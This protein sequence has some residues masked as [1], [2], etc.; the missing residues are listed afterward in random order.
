MPLKNLTFALNKLS[1]CLTF[2]QLAL[3]NLEQTFTWN[4][5][6]TLVLTQLF[7][8]M[9]DGE[10]KVNNGSIMIMHKWRGGEQKL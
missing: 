8:T 10:D 4:W 9:G 6:L 5:T 2:V 7:L 1:N 3:P